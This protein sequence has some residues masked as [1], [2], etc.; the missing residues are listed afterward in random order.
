MNLSLDMEKCQI[1]LSQVG[2]M[3]DL[4]NTENLW[5]NVRRLPF[6]IRS[7]LVE[8]ASRLIEQGIEPSF[9]DLLTFVKERATVANTMYGHYLHYESKSVQVKKLQMTSPLREKF[10]TLYTSSSNKFLGNG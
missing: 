7:R 4:N 10:V 8:R 1:N 6:N 3:S 9:D 5:K 2:F